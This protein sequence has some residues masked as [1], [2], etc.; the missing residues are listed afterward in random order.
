[1][2]DVD[3]RKDVLPFCVYHLIDKSQETY[4]GYISGPVVNKDFKMV[5]GTPPESGPYGKW[6]FAFKFYAINPMTRPIPY[7]M[8]L[9]CAKKRK[10]FPWDTEE[11]KLVYD[12]YNIEDDC[13][14]FITY[15]KPIP[16]TKPLFIHIKGIPSNPTNVFPSWDPN[17]P[18]VKEKNYVRVGDDNPTTIPQYKW[19]GDNSDLNTIGINFRNRQG[20]RH[21]KIFPMFVINHDIFGENYDNIRFTCN[22]TTCIPHNPDSSYV[23]DVIADINSVLYDKHPLPLTLTDCVVR[24][25]NLAPTQ[26]TG[27]DPFSLVTMINSELDKESPVFDIRILI[28][29]LVIIVCVIAYILCKK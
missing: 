28:P 12:P 17:P 5:C 14:Y 23:E 27:G 10:T 24:C 7:G 29:F 1:M 20:W 11:V 15:T 16:W 8:G 26:L 21:N 18:G 3:I 4:R 13:V 6:V 25:N 22:N 19:V 2:T 9:F